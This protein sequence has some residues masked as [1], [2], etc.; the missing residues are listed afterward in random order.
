MYHIVFSKVQNLLK[1]TESTDFWP[2]RGKNLLKLIELTESTIPSCIEPSNP[3][4]IESLPFFLLI[5]RQI[6]TT[7]KF[8]NLGS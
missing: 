2:K 1:L 4:K 3:E 6:N 5:F 7:P 8:S